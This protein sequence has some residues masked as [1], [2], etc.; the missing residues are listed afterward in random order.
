MTWQDGAVTA[1]ILCLGSKWTNDQ[2]HAYVA[3]PMEENIASSNWTLK[4]HGP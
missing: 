2:H 1:C 3:L 4:L